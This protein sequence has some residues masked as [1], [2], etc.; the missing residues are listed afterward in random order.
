MR[1]K[2]VKFVLILFLLQVLCL[3]FAAILILSI[4]EANG[5]E[6]H[7]IF[8]PSWKY[9]YQCCSNRDCRSIGQNVRETREGYVVPS[10][11]LIPYRDKKI[12]ISQDENFHW[13]TVGGKEE[14]KTICLYIPPRSF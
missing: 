3:L 14:S 8:S 13:C 5:H 7:S 2:I 1:S 9:D 11:E 12:K 10:G 4:R 6:I